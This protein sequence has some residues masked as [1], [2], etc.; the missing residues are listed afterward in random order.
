MLVL[1]IAHHLIII[2]LDKRISILLVSY[3]D[4]CLLSCNALKLSSLLKFSALPLH[5]K[6]LYFY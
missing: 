4:H 6:L 3:N 2:C 1:R 5:V